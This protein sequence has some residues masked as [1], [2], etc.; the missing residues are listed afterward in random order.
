MNQLYLNNSTKVTNKRNRYGYTSSKTES[1]LNF[2]Y[3][4]SDLI[5]KYSNIRILNSYKKNSSHFKESDFFKKNLKL[6]LNFNNNPRKASDDLPRL[7]L[8]SFS[9]II[10]GNSKRDNKFN[11]SSKESE[12][13]NPTINRLIMRINKDFITF[14]MF[15]NRNKEQSNDLQQNL[16]DYINT[17]ILI[18]KPIK[19]KLPEVSRNDNSKKFWKTVKRINGKRKLEREFMTFNKHFTKFNHS[20]CKE[21][22]NPFNITH[23]I[24]INHI[25]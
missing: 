11:E 7:N 6:D 14:R 2:K 15:Q 8:L 16:K 18:E 4:F 13:N 1:N 19:L 12:H 10:N 25:Y 17:D 23:K 20:Y 24:N 5:D 9:E 22:K 3:E 21:K